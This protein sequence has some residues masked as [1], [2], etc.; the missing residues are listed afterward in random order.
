MKTAVEDLETVEA[1]VTILVDNTIMELIPGSKMI[2]RLSR[3][4][5]SFIAEHG[6]SALIE[7]EG[8]RILVDTGATGIALDHNL[9]LVGLTVN[10]IDVV[11]FSHGHN[12]HTGGLHKVQGKII[13]HPDSFFQRYLVPREGVS[14]E[15]TSPDL[16]PEKHAVEFHKGPVKLAAGVVT[17][18]EIPRIHEW[19]ELNIFR[20][21]KEGEML[22]DRVFDDQGVAINTRK[23]LVIIAGCSHAGII[24]TIEQ[25]IKVTGVD[26][27]HCVIGG[28]HLIGPGESKIER[29]IEE[30]KRLRVQKIVPIHCTGFEAIKRISMAMPDEFEYGTAGCR[31]VF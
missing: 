19:E 14:Y 25:A 26:D 6:F 9:R 30:L 4:S 15:L 13:A 2:S 11:F 3:P 28:F 21:K 18:G 24:N 23:G 7:T 31:M 22:S 16:D 27:I 20:I 12:D 1:V 5:S 17:T 10:D 29:T 8:R